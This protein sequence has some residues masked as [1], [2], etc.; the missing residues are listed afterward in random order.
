MTERVA[1]TTRQV[2]DALSRLSGSIE[3]LSQ[4]QSSPSLAATALSRERSPTS[5][6][7]HVGGGRC[8]APHASRVC[9]ISPETVEVTTAAGNQGDLDLSTVAAGVSRLPSN[10]GPPERA[11]VLAD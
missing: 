10:R 3:A 9:G 4:I 5:A 2:Q 6:L 11:R 8:S 7:A 1:A